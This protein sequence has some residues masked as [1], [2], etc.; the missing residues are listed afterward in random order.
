M[1]QFLLTKPVSS[2]LV[3]PAMHR[4]Q[5]SGQEFQADH[6]AEGWR[7]RERERERD[8][9]KRHGLFFGCMRPDRQDNSWRFSKGDPNGQGMCVSENRCVQRYVNKGGG[10]EGFPS[11]YGAASTWAS[12]R[13]PAIVVGSDR[14]SFFFCGGGRGERSISITSSPLR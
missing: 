13:H 14:Y 5:A 11:R 2:P 1:L 8:C 12:L 9:E 6:D 4:L 10:C 7:A 3:V